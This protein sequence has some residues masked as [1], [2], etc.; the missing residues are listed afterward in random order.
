MISPTSRL[1][2][3]RLT[4][5]NGT[6]G[7]FGNRLASIIRPG[8]VSTRSTMSLPSASTVLKRVTIL[9]CR[10]ITSAWSAC[11]ISAWSASIMPSLGSFFFSRLR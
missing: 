9:V 3:T 1:R 11:S 2:S 7:F 10:L 8:V 4:I 5:S 6:L